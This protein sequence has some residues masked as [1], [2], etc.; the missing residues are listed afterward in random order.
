MEAP[1]TGAAASRAEWAYQTDA[2]LAHDHVGQQLKV[3]ICGIHEK[4]QIRDGSAD[5]K[6]SPR[7]G[8]RP[9]NRSGNH[10]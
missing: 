3:V 4:A 7:T 6:P 5:K 9:E 10:E 1:E 2:G 8:E